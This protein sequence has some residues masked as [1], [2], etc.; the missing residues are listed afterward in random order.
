MI[1]IRAFIEGER[2][3]RKALIL[4]VVNDRGKFS[5]SYCS[6]IYRFAN[7][8][9]FSYTDWIPEGDYLLKKI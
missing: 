1:F 2:R 9:R 5:G 8:I 7:V 4:F 6:K 3:L